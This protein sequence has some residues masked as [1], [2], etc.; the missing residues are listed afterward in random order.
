MPEEYRKVVFDAYQKKK[1]EGSLSSNLLDPT[2]GNVREECLIIYRERERDPKDDEIFKQFFKGVDKD[3]GYLTVLENSLAEKFKQMPKILKGGVPKYG[4]RYAELLAWLIDFQP[5][6]STSYYTSFYKDK[7]SDI[8]EVID[9]TD[10][11]I[12][13]TL[14]TITG[15]N[16]DGTQNPENEKI[17]KDEGENKQDDIVEE[18]KDSIVETTDMGVTGQLIDIKEK[19]KED[20]KVDFPEPEYVRLFSTRYITISCVILLLI[21]TTS[22]VAW[23]TSIASVRMPKEDEKCMYWNEDH[24]EPVKCNAQINGV[25]IIPLDL[26]KLQHQRKINLPDTLTTYSLGKVWYKGFVKDHEFFTDSGAYPQDIQRVLKP[27]TNTILTKYTSNYRYMLT[28]LVWFLCAALFVSLCGIGASKTKKKIKVG[29]QN[30]TS[31]SHI[32]DL[33]KQIAQ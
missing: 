22:F 2:P 29:N 32:Q 9:T 21:G 1:R 25:T 14:T 30:E 16:G 24:Y 15:G 33:L 28:R 19:E 7:P 12:G 8:E 13:E 5:R 10:V 3:K 18:V 31:N 26:K 17:N 6:P 20:T 23:E 27:L 4:L 11:K